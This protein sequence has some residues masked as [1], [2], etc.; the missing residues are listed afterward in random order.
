MTIDAPQTPSLTAQFDELQQ[1]FIK[2][3][4]LSINKRITVLKQLRSRVVE[5]EQELIDAVSKDFGYRTAFDTL[6]GDILP[7]MQALAH[8]I[9][10]L[11][12]WSK[13]SKR[14]V[15]L[16]LWP[17]KVSVTYQPKGV[18]GIIAPWNYPIQLAIVPVITALAAGNRTML[19]LSEFTPHTNQ[20][21]EKLFSGELE[22][23][24]KIIQGGSGVASEF[25][26]LPFAHLFFTGSIAVGKLVMGA[27]SA[28]LTPV[29]L[30]LGGK[31]PVIITEKADIK[32]AAQAI[33]FGKMAN[34]GQICVAPD[35]VFVPK[36]LE[37][38]LV[39][40]LCELYK[41]HYKQGVE[42]KNLT[43]IV[44]DAHYA[45]LSGYL[46]QAQ[47]LGS[48]IIKPLEDN[49]QDPD[50][51]RMGLHIVTQ[52]TDE[53]QLMKDELFGPILPVMSYTNLEHAISY[54]KQH[55]HPLALYILGQNK[56]I[57][58]YI[59]KQTLSGTV[60]VND[61]LVQVTA[62]DA[63]FGGVGHSGMGHYHAN[64]GFL[65]FSHAKN[66]LVSGSFNPRIG[67]LLKQSK[68]LIKLL[69]WLYIKK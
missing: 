13:P 64:E 11:P 39:Q 57:Q 52:V 31:S 40:H 48:T 50:K 58:E 24:C 12:K 61:T 21:L 55:H 41:K 26:S 49:Q 5:F 4:Y 53:M 35:Y 47:Q 56:Q 51:H 62:D 38:Q 9:K 18:V 54:I 3:P 14:S 60:A 65:T 6:L 32:K 44:S 42:G 68:V 30:E 23:H 2:T 1:Y 19:K 27:A 36:E 16:S 43:S 34:A 37:H 33:L 59:I 46:E 22:Q 15:G 17:S 7:T 10:K 63:P 8:T 20:V 28:N 29:T 66:T 67:M 45:R 25:S 69:K